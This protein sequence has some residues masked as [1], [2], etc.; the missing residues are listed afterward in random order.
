MELD[1]LSH[2]TA[3]ADS[4]KQSRR[5]GIN[6]GSVVN[7]LQQAGLTCRHY[8]FLLF[9]AVN[10]SPAAAT[11]TV[12][13]VIACVIQTLQVL[14]FAFSTAHQ[15]PW[16]STYVDFLIQ[17]IKVTRFDLFIDG[18]G[19][20]STNGT[21]AAVA[22]SAISAWILAA[23]ASI[24]I[25]QL[26]VLGTAS[27]RSLRRSRAGSAI[28]VQSL[29]SNTSSLRSDGQ[30]SAQTSRI[31][32]FS[33]RSSLHDASRST[34]GQGG[35]SVDV[36][37]FAAHS[38][39]LSVFT[40][41]LKWC[42]TVLLM[43]MVALLIAP[44]RMFAF[45]TLT[46][47][48]SGAL[49]YTKVIIGLAGLLALLPLVLSYHTFRWPRLLRLPNS[50]LSI[51]AN[52]QP[53]A[54]KPSDVASGVNDALAVA[55]TRFNLL[56]T[57]MNASLT[58]I[59]TLTPATSAMTRWVLCSL[60][61]TSS[62]IKLALTYRY[63]PHYNFSMVRLHAATQAVLCWAGFALTITLMYHD[64]SQVAG[65]L[66]FWTGSP[67]VAAV[68]VLLVTQRR[69]NLLQYARDARCSKDKITDEHVAELVVRVMLSE[70][71]QDELLQ[72][73]STDTNERGTNCVFS[74]ERVFVC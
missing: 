1:G 21:L 38:T 32:D 64:A 30:A 8:W 61:L 68:V 17:L 13:A 23:L 27:E 58:A 53:S 5:H 11:D 39:T 14:W 40:A 65:A 12:T 54:V 48:D 31:F 63:M 24:V 44:L 60:F 55:N 51:A 42:S 15:F 19:A 73:G 6:G 45:T 10:S 16:N 72:H 71:K 4:S 3:S 25:Y 2:T 18:S 37:H 62:V 46:S 49:E 47:T 28:A 52:A 43:P 41:L 33:M 9:A 50:A 29:E 69:S 66:L 70:L 7:L 59:Y 35:T 57:L 74:S 67:L 56:F 22:L 34:G 20:D 36:V 26:Y